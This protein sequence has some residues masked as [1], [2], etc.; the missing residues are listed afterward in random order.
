MFHVIILLYKGG[1]RNVE[2]FRISEKNQKRLY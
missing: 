1:D 2:S